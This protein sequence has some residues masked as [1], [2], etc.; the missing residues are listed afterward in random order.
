MSEHRRNAR[1]GHRTWWIVVRDRHKQ[2]IY[3]PSMTRAEPIGDCHIL[4]AH[5][6]AATTIVTGIPAV[7][8]LS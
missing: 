2:N 4:G 1:L 7:M 5:G 8:K 6:T 3:G